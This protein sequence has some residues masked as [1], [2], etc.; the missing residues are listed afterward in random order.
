MF[1]VRMC[2]RLVT[3]VYFQSNNKKKGNKTHSFSFK[4]L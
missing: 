4:F 2:L 1:F 3:P